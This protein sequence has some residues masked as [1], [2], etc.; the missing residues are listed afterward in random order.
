MRVVW[1]EE[2]ARLE[3]RGWVRA[4]AGEECASLAAMLP[5]DDDAARLRALAALVD[6]VLRR[7]VPLATLERYPN[8][9]P[10]VRA[11]PPVT[12]SVGREQARSILRSLN[13]SGPSAVGSAAIALM[14]LARFAQAASPEDAAIAW[15]SIFYSSGCLYMAV[16]RS[17]R[18]GAEDHQI[19]AAFL[20][21]LQALRAG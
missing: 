11:L 15:R 3:L 2:D 6:C 10:L 12:D 1:N 5:L 21:T 13:S 14:H 17:R 20:E 18:A 19:R 4:V 9:L 8:V 16:Y 7:I